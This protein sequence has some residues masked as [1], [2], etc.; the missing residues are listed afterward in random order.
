MFVA[1]N[2]NIRYAK[3]L[4]VFIFTTQRRLVV[5]YRRF[6]TTYRSH[7]QASSW[8]CWPLKVGPVGCLETSVTT[9]IRCVTCQESEDLIYTGTD[10]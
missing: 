10:A 2:E 3:L 7:F 8:T 1:F 4:G 6:G 9:D 5:I